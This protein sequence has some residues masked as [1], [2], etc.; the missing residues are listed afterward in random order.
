MIA[1]IALFAFLLPLAA[2]AQLQ[3]FEFDGTNDTPVGAL[4]NVGT[5]APGDTL[6][7]RFHVRNIGAGP[8]TL[9]TLALSG[10]GFSIISAPTLPYILAPYVGPA[11]EAEVDVNFSP[12][13]IGSFSAFMVVNSISIALQ[14]TCVASAILTLSGSQTP[15]TAGATVGF[16]S[17]PVGASQ[18]QSFVLYDSSSTSVTVS[19]VSVSG[20]A[21]KLAPGL[22]LPLQIGSGQSVPFQ[23]T[24]TP[25]SGTA[26]QGTLTVD[27]RTFTLTGQGLDPPLPS[28]TIVFASSVGA[29]GQQNSITIPLAAASQVSGSGTLAIG[30]QPSVT[31]VT[32]DAAVQFLSGPLRIATVTIAV[33]ATSAVIGGQ[34]SMAFQT[35]TTAGTITFTLTLE[36]NPPLQTSLAIPPE[37]INLDSATAVALFGSINVA[38]S[39]FDNTYSASQL[40]FTFYDVTGKAL[41]QGAIDVNAT[42]AFQ[43][44]FST[45]QVGGAFQVLAIFPVTGNQAEIGFVTAQVAN[46]LGTTTAQQVPIGN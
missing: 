35:G 20:G 33:G 30:F 39:G 28:A 44:Y 24:F 16:G 23:I 11:S 31:G 43:Q 4:L 8:A 13:T 42:T 37:P 40:T 32:D 26:Y 3:V 36:N 18:A 2:M 9:T 25:Q 34:S 7:T 45:S 29:S 14:G 12:A 21:F 5:A 6:E 17:V 1:R 22:T 19:S 27:G 41:P 10:Q 46:S 15:L 38:F